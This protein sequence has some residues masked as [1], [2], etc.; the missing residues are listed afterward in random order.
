MR[1]F[2]EEWNHQCSSVVVVGDLCTID[3]CLYPC[4]NRLSFK[5]YNPNKPAKYGILIKCLN[6]VSFPFTYR[7]VVFAGKPELVQEAQYHTP[8]T[9]DA[10]VELLSGYGWRKL[11]GGE[12]GKLHDCLA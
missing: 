2:F 7:S 4:R 1:D 6:E 3:E 11:H 12:V 5:T 10:T 9:H 8:S